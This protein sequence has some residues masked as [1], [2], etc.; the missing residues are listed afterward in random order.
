MAFYFFKEYPKIIARI[1]EC[2]RAFYNAV[3]RDYRLSSIAFSLL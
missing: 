3:L 1:C 2:I